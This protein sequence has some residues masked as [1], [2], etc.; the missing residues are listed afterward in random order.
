MPKNK[1]RAN[2]NSTKKCGKGKTMKSIAF[3]NNKGG[4]SKTTTVLNVAYILGEVYKNKVL[5]V[6]CDGQ[7]NA[8]RFLADELNEDGVEKIL[9]NDAISPR[10]ALSITRYAHINVLTS[11]PGM[12]RCAEQFQSLSE[13]EREYNLSKLS[14]FWS[15]QYDYVLLDLPPAL[16]S[17]TEQLIGITNGVI[18]PVELGSFA[19]QGIAKV[20]ETINRVGAAF[21]GCFISKY[22]KKNK[23]DEELKRLLNN[24]LGNKV[25]STVIPY[26]NIIRNSL[27]YKMTA[28]EYMHWLGPAKKYVELTEEIIRKVG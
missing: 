23:A 9:I 17:L 8:S 5:V 15:E 11:T 21:T 22:D 10:E 2:N 6:D 19:I 27:I 25:F 13:A 20:T 4:V 24:N 28:Y 26:S 18:V 7:Q 16:N 3:F 1:N 12:N 14:C